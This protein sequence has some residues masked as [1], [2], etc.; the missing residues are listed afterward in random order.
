MEGS[1][2]ERNAFLVR[3]G[4]RLFLM[5]KQWQEIFTRVERDRESFRRYYPMARVKLDDDA[6]WAVLAW[7]TN[8]A[9]YR[10]FAERTDP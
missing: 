7:V 9:L 3:E 10:H 4:G 2:R 8:D 5:E 6:R 1:A